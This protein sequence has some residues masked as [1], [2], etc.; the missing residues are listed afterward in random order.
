MRK[1][2]QNS[3]FEN[4]FK[5]E[6]GNFASKYTSNDLGNIL[7]NYANNKNTNRKYI[8]LS[9][10]VSITQNVAS[11]ISSTDPKKDLD[12]I[13]S[14]KPGLKDRENLN[15]KAKPSNVLDATQNN[16]QLHNQ[17]N[18]T[19]SM[20]RST[21]DIL[22][23]NLE[24]E[25]KNK[26]KTQ[27]DMN[28]SYLFRLLNLSNKT[29]E[30]K[31]NK[32]NNPITS[33]I[34][35]KQENAKNNNNGNTMNQ[36]SSE[37]KNLSIANEN[38]DCSTNK[39]G[40]LRNKKLEGKETAKKDLSNSRANSFK[41]NNNLIEP[42]VDIEVSMNTS[43]NPNNDLE[44]PMK[45]D[46]ND[47][48]HKEKSQNRPSNLS[49]DNISLVKNYME[50]DDPNNLNINENKINDA[51][52]V[53]APSLNLDK[54]YS[55]NLKNQ[56]TSTNSNIN[57]T[58]VNLEGILQGLVK[59]DKEKSLSQKNLNFQVNDENKSHTKEANISQL[60]DINETSDNI[61]E[62]SI[63][64]KYLSSSL[65]NNIDMKPQ[66]S[67]SKLIQEESA[68]NNKSQMEQDKEQLD[69]S[70]EEII[71][72]EYSGFD[73]DFFKHDFQDKSYYEKPKYNKNYSKGKED[74]QHTKSIF[75]RSKDRDK[76]K[77]RDREKNF[78][79]KFHEKSSKKY[80]IHNFYL[81]Q[82]KLYFSY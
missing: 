1:N 31:I 54:K 43:K 46:S 9:K 47:L 35:Q 42:K 33:I 8:P 57:K 22:M 80:G 58:I 13:E 5:L 4:F 15:A 61:Q 49:N 7:N 79:S 39:I 18:P 21:N 37:L 53:Q 67:T 2:P 64:I 16:Y 29:E 3:I 17:K 66:D 40:K 28:T 45:A 44:E 27:V 69:E 82:L 68:I 52:K 60:S 38:K 59:F 14:N 55:A 81:F 65:S 41:L 12:E 20:K 19:N 77:E 62:S 48:N 75:D 11:N 26:K 32:A 10:I 63:N 76:D 70:S 78:S 30:N 24:E 51:K 36:F 56:N 71:D 72:M 73:S 23:L 50:T 74:K 25:E 6:N 34:N